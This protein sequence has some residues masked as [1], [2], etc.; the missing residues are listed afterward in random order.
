MAYGRSTMRRSSTS[1]ILRHRTLAAT[2]LPLLHP[3]CSYGFL[4][5]VCEKYDR[6]EYVLFNAAR[7]PAQS[8]PDLA[9]ASRLLLLRCRLC[10]RLLPRLLLPCQAFN[11]LPLATIIDDACLV[12]HAGI[13]AQTSLEVAA[14][15]LD[16]RAESCSGP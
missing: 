15:P 14:H 11:H 9:S 12:L 3:L 7:S 2:P 6:T 10:R 8:R 16:P 4:A 1:Y 5:E 13:D